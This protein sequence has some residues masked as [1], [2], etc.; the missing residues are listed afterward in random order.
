MSQFLTRYAGQL[1]LLYLGFTAVQQVGQGLDLGSAPFE[2]K[3]ISLF[4]NNPDSLQIASNQLMQQFGQ[5]FGQQA[6]QPMNTLYNQAV[7]PVVNQM[8]AIQRQGTAAAQGL[9]RPLP[10]ATAYPGQR[11]QQ[12][13]YAPS[14]VQPHRPGF[15]QNMELPAGGMTRTSM[16]VNYER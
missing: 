4:E 9:G 1:L 5:Q 12:R 15:V 16:V 13:N 10:N 7:V 2:Q 8:A 14:S 11:V 6:A 3:M